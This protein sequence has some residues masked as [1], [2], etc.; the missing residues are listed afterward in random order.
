MISRRKIGDCEQANNLQSF[1]GF[2]MGRMVDV[3]RFR[4]R[5]LIR[6]EQSSTDVAK[7]CWD[8]L[9]TYEKC[10]LGTD[11]MC[12]SGL[13]T[14]EVCCE[15]KWRDLADSAARTGARLIDSVSERPYRSYKYLIGSAFDQ[16]SVRIHE[17]QT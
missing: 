17:I 12:W 11:P 3:R 6:Q 7:S 5:I 4:A 1:D 9:Y 8:G 10:C 2:Y 13:Y 16:N 14:R 15:A